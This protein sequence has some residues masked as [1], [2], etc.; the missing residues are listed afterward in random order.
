MFI[1]AARGQR[2]AEGQCRVPVLSCMRLELVHDH[3]TESFA[4]VLGGDED[5]G[6]FAFHDGTRGDDRPRSLDHDRVTGRCAGKDGVVRVEALEVL[7]CPRRVVRLVARVD[8]A[9]D[10]LADCGHIRLLKG[11]QLHPFPAPRCSPNVIGHDSRPMTHMVADGLRSRVDA[12]VSSQPR[13]QR[14]AQLAL[15]SSRS[16]IHTLI[17]D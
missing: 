5:A 3:V 10:E 7:D 13:N 9:V 11:S 4:L 12:L 2:D 6:D 1:E 8:G 15:C 16:A 17:M 14:A